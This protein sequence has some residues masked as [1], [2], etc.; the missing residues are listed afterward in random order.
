MPW[1]SPCITRTV[2][3]APGWSLMIFIKWFFFCIG[4]CNEAEGKKVNHDWIFLNGISQSLQCV[5][6][7]STTEYINLYELCTCI[8]WK[9]YVLY[10]NEIIPSHDRSKSDCNNI[11]SHSKEHCFF[12]RYLEWNPSSKHYRRHVAIKVGTQQVRNRLLAPVKF[13]LQIYVCKNLNMR[14]FNF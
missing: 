9:T 4:S 8:L 7:Y 11:E 13:T 14:R 6:M 10:N 12:L 2:N 3:K 5:H 1:A